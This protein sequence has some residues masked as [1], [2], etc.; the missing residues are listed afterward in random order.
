MG[1]IMI[2]TVKILILLFLEKKLIFVV[3]MKHNDE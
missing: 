1:T 2:I 3:S